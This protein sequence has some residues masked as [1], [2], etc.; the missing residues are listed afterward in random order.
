MYLYIVGRGHSGSTLLDILLAHAKD[1]EGVGEIA[2]SFG[3][4]A[5]CCSCGRTIGDCSFWRQVAERVERATGS[6]PRTAAL[7]RDSAHVRHFPATL[8]A[9]PEGTRARA[10][11]AAHTALARAL[12]DVS[13]KT[14]IVDSSKEPTR[15]LF[16]ARFDPDARIVHLV[17]HPLGV[18]ASHHRRVA[19]GDRFLFLRRRFY[20]RHWRV[21]SVVVAAASWTVGNL[22]CE[23]VGLFAADR[24]VRIRYEDLLRDPEGELRRIGRVCGIDPGPAIARLRA[25][26]P[27]QVGHHIGGNRMRHERRIVL[28]PARDR[29]HDAPGWARP[30]VWLLCW[31]MMWR[32]GYGRSRGPLQPGRQ[33]VHGTN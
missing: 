12:A 2:S 31:P 32:Y 10:L 6:F 29:I 14:H 27:F 26:E 22:L 28:D 33:P 23:I 8:L 7:I 24:M 4:T 20:G 13:G 15:A 1:V 16:L 11:H 5:S 17:R 25:G 18:V 30:V 3:K 21:L 9:R 19:A